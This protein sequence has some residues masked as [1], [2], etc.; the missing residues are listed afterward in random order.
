MTGHH[1]PELDEVE[2][3]EETSPRRAQAAAPGIRAKSAASAVMVT[4]DVT[5]C[6]W[7]GYC[8]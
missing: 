4:M 2:D 6:G 5:E 1:R 8:R 3:E 7:G